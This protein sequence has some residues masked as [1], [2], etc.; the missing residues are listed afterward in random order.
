MLFSPKTAAF[1][2]ACA[3]AQHAWADTSA[4]DVQIMPEVTVKADKPAGEAAG[5]QRAGPAL[6]PQKAR[7]SDSASLLDDIPGLSRKAAG[8]VSSLP[9]LRGFADDRLQAQVD[10]MALLSSCPNHMNS[11]LSYVDASKVE[12]VKVYNGAA[13]VSAGGDNIGGAIVAKSAPPKFA[14]AGQTLTTGEAG[15][16][17][18]SN[19]EASGANLSATTAN[20]HLSLRYSGSTSRSDNYEA[21]QAFKKG[22]KAASDKAWLDGDVV[23]SSAYKTENHE[24]SLAW[25]DGIHLLEGSVGIQRVPYEG[26]ANQRMD[27]TDNHSNQFNLHYLGQYGWGDL[28]ARVYNQYVRHSMQFG[29]DKQYAYGSYGGM[30]MESQSRTIGGNIVAD[31][32]LAPR[33]RLKL[34]TE[35]QQ[36]RLNDW[37]PPAGAGMGMMSPNTFWNINDGKRDRV[38]VFAE[39]Q[40]D[41]TPQ[42][43]SILGARASQVTSNAGN[44]AGYNSMASYAND[45]AAFNALDHKKTD[46]NIDLSALARYS[47][48]ANQQYELAYAQKTRSP[49]LY[50]RYTWSSMGMAAVMNNFVG[51]GN[52][53]FGDVNLKPETAHTVSA[54]AG[55][56]SADQDSWNLTLSPYY[57]Y[58]ENYIDA[59]RCGTSLCGGAANLTAT[60]KFVNL[61]YV[62]QRAQLYGVEISGK[63]RLAASNWGR[64]DLSGQ[65]SYSRGENLDTGD[66]LYNIMPLNAKLALTHT[67]GAWSNTAEWI[68]VSAKTDV[69]QTRNEIQT[70]G[71][72]LLNLR[73]RYGWKQLTVDFGIDNLFNHYYVQPLG[74][75]YI[76]QGMTMSKNGVAWGVGVPGPARSLYTALNYKF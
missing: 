5:A 54:T 34:G 38:D 61:Q 42:W 41:W 11:P 50:E 51:D 24:L 31:I 7:S 75:A 65:I 49:N 60:D 4:N 30:P 46:H 71:Y 58:V 13:P 6:A 22:G 45:A 47:P 8:G 28:D 18:R 29:D 69:S 37:W 16:F 59:K 21:A 19:G 53:Y 66:N 23:G 12:S 15:A 20:D 9:V 64:L 33:H 2:V 72:S 32:D 56:H 10:G 26:F 57:S 17:Y 62:N 43:R 25:R 40:A 27:M 14:E 63:A 55:W 70:P 1:A 35:F 68:A 74:G 44:V 76:G 36:Y 3:L 39:W 67:L 48:S 73:T 52:G